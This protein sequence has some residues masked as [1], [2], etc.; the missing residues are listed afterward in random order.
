[1]KA[2][3]TIILLL[4]AVAALMKPVAMLPPEVFKDP[5]FASESSGED[6]SD[7][8]EYTEFA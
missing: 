8:G 7:A 2:G 4:V 3:W 1:M 6:S 5:I